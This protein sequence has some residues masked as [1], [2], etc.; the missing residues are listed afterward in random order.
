MIF[1]TEE[2]HSGP[3]EVSLSED[4]ETPGMRLSADINLG[5]DMCRKSVKKKV[6]YCL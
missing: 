5:F 3:A 2:D 1:V 6:I 4:D